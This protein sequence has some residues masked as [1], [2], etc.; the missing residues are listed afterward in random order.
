[1]PNGGVFKHL[2][3]VLVFMKVELFGN[4]GGTG[5]IDPKAFGKCTLPFI[6]A[7]GLL[8]YEVVSRFDF[9]DDFL[10][11]RIVYMADFWK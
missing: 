3:W 11:I 5:A 1:M 4:V 2:L 9:L 8:E 7:V 10:N 6:F